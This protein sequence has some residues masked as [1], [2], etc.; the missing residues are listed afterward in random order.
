MNSASKLI[1]GTVQFGTDYGINNIG[2][3]PSFE[4]VKKIL[5]F[6]VSK[7]NLI[8]DTAEAY[9]NS[10]QV[11]GRYHE[12]S[13]NKLEVITKFS[14]RFSYKSLKERIDIDLSYLNTKSLYAY[15]FHSFLDLEDQFEKK[16]EELIRLKKSGVI[17]KIGVS[18]YSNEEIQK[19]IDFY[20][21]DLIQ[22]PFNMLDNY[23]LRGELMK[24]LSRKK[25]EIHTRSVFL[26][27]LF[28][29]DPNALPT[30][31]LPLKK[32]LNRLIEIKNDYS[33]NTIDM[34]LGYVLS[35]SEINK[36][37]IG[38]DSINQLESNF[39]SSEKKISPM[40]ISEINELQIDEIDLLNPSNWK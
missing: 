39:I 25:I 24:K 19:V 12:V 6:F 37:L 16:K 22:I 40:I 15:M 17:G 4:E 31:L 1:L 7:G 35:F 20:D 26:Q 11:I 33:I 21:V 3:K 30:K 9:G 32:H 13:N 8:I 23:S 27:G 34:A 5:D 28:F 29:I 36:T 18:V 10:Q 2:G 38:V 14:S